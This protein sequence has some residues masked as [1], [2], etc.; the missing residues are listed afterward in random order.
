MESPLPVSIRTDERVLFLGL[1]A[2]ELVAA[3]ARQ[4][5][6][7]AVVIVAE[8]DA[9]YQARKAF[10]DFDNV[11]VVPGTPEEL[12][13]RDGFFTVVVDTVGDWPDAAKVRQELDRVTARRAA[14]G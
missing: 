13:W 7:G 14:N 1:P 10:R 4:A 5:S 2:A 11:M 6:N 8:G 3:T 12:P 9:V